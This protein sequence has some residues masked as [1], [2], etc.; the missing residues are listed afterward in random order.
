MADQALHV[1]FRASRVK[2]PHGNGSGEYKRDHRHRQ[3]QRD[4]DKKRRVAR[5]GNQSR[6]S[7]G[8]KP[9]RRQTHC[10]KFYQGDSLT[11][12]IHRYVRDL[13][14]A[15]DIAIDVFTDLVVHPK[16][17]N[18]ETKLKTYLF[19]LGRSRALNYIKWRQRRQRL[20]QSAMLPEETELS[21]RLHASERRE[22]VRQA[23]SQL[24]LSMREAVELVYFQGLSYQEAGGIMRKT[25]KQVDN[26]LYR[27]KGALRSLLGK[28][29]EELL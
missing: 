21:E 11:F 16:R 26:L 3:K 22:V 28:E 24:P 9:D 20:E 13:D 8:S 14:A 12:F 1:G 2:I 29:G 19:M 27:A 18:F 15:E 7:A 10:S 25:P 5:G 23:L 17:Y 4:L 6:Q